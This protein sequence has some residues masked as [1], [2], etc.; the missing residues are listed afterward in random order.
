MQACMIDEKEIQR[1][2]VNRGY[3][4]GV[5]EDPPGQ[6][7]PD[8]SHEVEELFMLVDGIVKV[9]LGKE[10]LYPKIGE[11][12]FI[13]AFTTHTVENIGSTPNR[14]FYGFKQ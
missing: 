12:V 8:E 3:N 6:I 7:W 2:W 4:F 11:E 10:I 14:W 9:T 1:D 13:P 5:W